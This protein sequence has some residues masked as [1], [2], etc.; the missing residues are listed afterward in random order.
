MKD[1]KDV[2]FGKNPCEIVIE[3]VNEYGYPVCCGF[4]AGHHANNQALPISRHCTLKVDKFGGI[5]TLGS[6]L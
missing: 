1:E 4:P 5:L 2:P 6:N 3:H